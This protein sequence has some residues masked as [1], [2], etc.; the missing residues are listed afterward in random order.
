MAAYRYFR[1]RDETL[2]RERKDGTGGGEILWP[3]GEWAPWFIKRHDVVEITEE[4]ACARFGSLDGPPAKNA[5]SLE[6]QLKDMRAEEN[7]L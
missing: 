6:E 1:D 5:R 4:E 7:L 2:Q 3:S